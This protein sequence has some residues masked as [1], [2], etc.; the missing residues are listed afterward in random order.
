[1]SKPIPFKKKWLFRKKLL[2]YP[3]F[4]LSLIAQN[5]AVMTLMCIGI[6]LGVQSGFNDLYQQGI[7]EKLPTAHPYFQFIHYQ[8]KLVL[9]YLLAS[10]GGGFLISSIWTLFL[11][12][13][14]AGPIVRLRGY[15]DQASKGENVGP[16]SFR[17]GDFFLEIPGALNGAFATLKKDQNQD[18][19]KNL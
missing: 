13:K 14:V 15:L 16:I 11:S 6:Y 18:Q 1:M 17:K 10:L 8:S 3:R 4:Q 9:N 7:A 5:F 12:H 2:I 19:K